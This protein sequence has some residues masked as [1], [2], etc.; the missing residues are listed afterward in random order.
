[1]FFNPNMATGLKKHHF[2]PCTGSPKKIIEVQ[3]GGRGGPGINP[4]GRHT[5]VSIFHLISSFGSILGSFGPFGPFGTL[6]GPFGALLG[7]FGPIF[8]H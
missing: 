1:M 7:S 4:L 6:V 2:G 5:R 8:Q 3:D